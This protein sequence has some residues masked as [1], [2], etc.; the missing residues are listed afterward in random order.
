MEPIGE[1]TR[2]PSAF[3]LMVSG[4]VGSTDPDR[5]DPG[6]ILSL[7]VQ[8]PSP[9]HSRSPLGGIALALAILVAP[10]GLIV[11]IVAAALSARSLGY[12]SGLAKSAIVVSIVFC[13]TLAGG[14][15]AYSFSANH[16]AHQD[17]LRTSSAPMCK[18]I[19]EKPGVLADA[20]FGWPPL[21]VTIPAYVTAVASYTTWWAN[22]AK[23]APKQI[24]PQVEAIEKAA[25]AASTRMA[26]SKVV[27]HDQ[28]SA[29]L[30]KV[31]AAST[32]P[33]WAKSYCA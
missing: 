14:G 12:V 5:T 8:A 18:L 24:R 29:D 23:V 13:L 4:A 33:Q 25:Q 26:L 1:E 7:Q 27:D 22:L 32:L 6:R 17:A 21:G 10:L 16:R 28:D 31:A 30:Q 11:G 9:V 20:A 3:E 15:V 19:A 2:A